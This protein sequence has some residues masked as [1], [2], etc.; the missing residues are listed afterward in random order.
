M[1]GGSTPPPYIS[2]PSNYIWEASLSPKTTI[3]VKQFASYFTKHRETN[4]DSI[5]F[6]DCATVN[7]TNIERKHRWTKMKS[8]IY[9]F[10]PLSSARSN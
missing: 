10:S 4:G 1:K 3:T 9:P 7:C 8:N 5:V 6:E 2:K